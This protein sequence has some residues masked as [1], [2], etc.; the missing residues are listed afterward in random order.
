MILRSH[1]AKVIL[2]RPAQ[3]KSRAEKP[4]PGV[5][6]PRASVDLRV[7]PGAAKRGCPSMETQLEHNGKSPRQSKEPPYDLAR[8]TRCPHLLNKLWGDVGPNT[9]GFYIP[10]PARV[11][12]TPSSNSLNPEMTRIPA[13]KGSDPQDSPSSHPNPFPAIRCQLQVQV[14]TRASDQLATNWR[15]P[16]SHPWVRLIC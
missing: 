6:G 10:A 4:A 16:R 2:L 11:F 9:P 5:W 7:L 14:V 12:P 1:V 3:P 13:V 8:P 15:F